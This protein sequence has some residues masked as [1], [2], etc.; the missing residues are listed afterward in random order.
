MN[1]GYK[2]ATVIALFVIIMSSMVYFAFKQ[3]NEMMDKNYY[4]KELKYQSYINASHA[5]DSI[6]TDTLIRFNEASVFI[7]IPKILTL[8]FNKGNVEFIRNDDQSKDVLLA[9][10][11]DTSGLFI[12]D[13]SRF[14]MGTYNVRVEWMSNNKTYY[15]EQNL[16][17]V[18]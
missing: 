9:I 11:P 3:S 18:M 12:I 5:L 17:I 13:K 15:R 16:S 4:Q 8:N 6:S 7:Q 14:S 1:W 2:I 10:T